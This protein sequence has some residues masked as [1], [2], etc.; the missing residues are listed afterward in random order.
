MDQYV[1]LSRK[2]MVGL[3]VNVFHYVFIYIYCTY[4]Y[5][6][7]K[8]LIIIGIRL[9]QF[10]LVASLILPA[11]LLYLSNKYMSSSWPL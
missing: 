9:G 7:H 4:L 3:N 5:V 11:L 8:Y 6:Y 1:Q 10:D 2:T